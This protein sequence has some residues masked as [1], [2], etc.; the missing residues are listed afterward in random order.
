MAGDDF[1]NETYLGLV[2]MLGP[3]KARVLIKQLI[4]DLD[5][6]R[7]NLKRATLDES[8]AKLDQSTHVLASLA[9]TVGAKGIH[10]LA[11]DVNDQ[12]IASNP[13]FPKGDVELLLSKIDP[14][15]AFLV[16][17]TQSFGSKE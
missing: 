1:Q 12:A 16:A 5:V 11:K 15:M 2:K 7:K 6:A 3:E 4:I 9:G 10:Q 8:M 13:S 14:W 17:E